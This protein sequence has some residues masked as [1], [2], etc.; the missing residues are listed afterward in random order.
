MLFLSQ[1]GFFFG[2]VNR[3]RYG[4]F[5]G[6]SVGLVIGGVLG[7]FA[8]LTILAFPWSLIGIIAGVI[9]ATNL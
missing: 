9:V 1:Y 6:A 7:A 5:L 2:A 4:T 8:G 3:I